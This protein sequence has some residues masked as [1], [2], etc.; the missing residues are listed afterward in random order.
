MLSGDAIRLNQVHSKKL[1]VCE[2]IETGLAIIAASQNKI[3]VWVFL[4]AGNLAKADIPQG[5]F[6]EVIIY[7]DR[8]PIDQKQ[9]GV[10][11]SIMLSYC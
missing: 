7:A 4:N 9:D 11:A 2:G 3:A 8:D 6:D 10:Q 5:M 1:A